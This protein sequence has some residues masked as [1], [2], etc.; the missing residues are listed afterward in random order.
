MLDPTY[1]NIMAIDLGLD[2]LCAITFKNSPQQ[3]LINGKT[4]KSKNAYFN[5]EIAHLTSIQVKQSNANHCKPTNRIRSLQQKR[6]RMIN[7][8]LHKA[9]KTLIQLAIQ[10]KCKAIILGDIKGIKQYN[11]NKSFVQIPLQTLVSQIEYKATLNGIIVK[12]TTEEYTSGV[13]AF[14]LE[15]ISSQYYNYSR[16]IKRGLFRTNQGHLVNSDI[17]GSLNIMRKF[18]AEEKLRNVVPMPVKRLRDNGCLD[19]PI[20][21]QITN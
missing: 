15:P 16:R 1:K 9:S 19:H 17:N 20:R 6:N 7:S 10:H 5:K 21:L 4:L 14:D 18:L 8:G 12:K 3:Y 13:S 11:K 2:N